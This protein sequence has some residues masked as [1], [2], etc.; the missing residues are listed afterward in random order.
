MELT[1]IP[2]LATAISLVVAWALFAILCSIASEGI[3]Q[4]KA[5]RGRFMRAHLL[6]QLFD[7]PNDINWGSLLYQHGSIDLLTLNSDKPTSDIAPHLFAE[8]M[9]EIVGKAQATQMRKAEVMESIP[10]K[11]VLL[12]DFK[13]ATM[14]LQ[15]SD[16][17]G[18]LT[19]AMTNAELC[20]G[21][22]EENEAKVYDALVLQ[23]KSWY[24]QMG[25]RMSSWYGKKTRLRLFIMGSLIALLV[26]VD[27]I[28][29]FKHFNEND[30]SRKVMMAYYE[31][32]AEQLNAYIAAAPAANAEEA[33]KM[34]RQYA[35]S[36]KAL[37]HEAQLPV[38]WDHSLF[39]KTPA[40]AGWPFKILGILL[41]GVAASFG[42][43]FWFQMLKKVYTRKTEK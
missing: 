39:V 28:Q 1:S 4:I 41:S 36:M 9:I 6:R 12:R 34:V 18:F 21:T 24:E 8:T 40:P 5:E 37:A 33:V 10:Y 17:M 27:S 30:S 11:S 32:N 19:Q 29:L 15:P 38:G 2:I 13:A 14:V 22:G 25:Q 20:G 43:P 35:D 16:V 7:H 42:A 3:A 26:N 31:N 23:I